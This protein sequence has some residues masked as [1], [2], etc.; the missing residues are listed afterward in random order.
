MGDAVY[1][2]MVTC[3]YMEAMPD[4]SMRC[5]GLYKL[6]SQTLKWSQLSAESDV[7]GPTKKAG[8]RMFYFSKNKVAVIGGYGPPP[9]LFQPGASFI[10]NKRFTNGHGWTNE[11]HVFDT[12]EC[13]FSSFKCAPKQ[14]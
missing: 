6:S 7:N 14:R 5:G 12:D 1:L 11:I 13:K 4:G 10:K 8:C 3:M 9:A 2:Q